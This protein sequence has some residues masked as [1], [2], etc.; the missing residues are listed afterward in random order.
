V[1]G[2]Q[3]TNKATSP[4]VETGTGSAWQPASTVAVPVANGTGA[5][6]NG[7]S[8]TKAGTCLA[9]GTY[10]D[11]ALTTHAMAVLSTG[12]QWGQ[13]AKAV[14]VELPPGPGGSPVLN[15]VSCAGTGCLAVG[16][17]GQSFYVQPGMAVA[18]SGGQFQRAVVVRPPAS[19]PGFVLTTLT[20]VSCTG[21][22]TCAVSGNYLNPKTDVGSAMVA[23]DVDGAWQ[24][25]VYIEPPEGINSSLSGVSCVSAGD[26]VAVGSYVD[27]A[28][29]TVPM[30]VDETDGHWAQGVEIAIPAGAGGASLDGVACSPGGVC[31]VVGTAHNGDGIVA[32]STAATS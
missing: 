12:G 32:L 27:S 15:A 19:S 8:C 14:E 6:L 2:Y 4:L 7:V 29:V 30:Y 28:G 5:V 26:C 31:A 25:S 10:S 11:S 20:G 13:G 17:Y 22:A 3:S 16:E 1:G 18:E 9:V 21:P 23:N 24:P